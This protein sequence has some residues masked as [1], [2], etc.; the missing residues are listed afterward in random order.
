MGG[1]GLIGTTL[2]EQTNFDFVFSSKD[3]HKI[4]SVDLNGSNIWLSCLPATKWKVNENIKEDIYN[5]QYIIKL[6]SK[7]KF[8]NVILFSTIDVYSDSPLESNENYD[9]NISSF[10]YGANRR[11][12]ELL[13]LQMLTY[14]N[15][16]IFRLPALFGKHIKKNVLYD[17]LNYNQVEKIA[18][19]SFYQWYDLNDLYE[20]VKSRLSTHPKIYN[21][22]PEP[23]PTSN[24]I[25]LF[26]EHKS[27]V[28][29]Y[30]H[31]ATYNYKTYFTNTQYL[32]SREESLA[33]ISK[34]VHDARSQ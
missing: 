14:K 29:N 10:N 11:L 34:F 17:L 18:A 3:V 22:F 33:K 27:I 4:D 1:S 9:P 5:M 31:G 8:N 32:Y 21:L 20:D 26:P 19:K 16:K 6:L 13:V 7:A 24:I 12:F 15:V 25:E 2:Q 30:T 23:V 28:D